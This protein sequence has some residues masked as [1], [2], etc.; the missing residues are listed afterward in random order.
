VIKLS[1]LVVRQ[2]YIIIV[3]IETYASLH[4][5]IF[6][7][8]CHEN[9]NFTFINCPVHIVSG[10]IQEISDWR[11]PDRNGIYPEKDL[12]RQWPE[13]GPETAWVFEGR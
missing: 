10:K 5:H 3:I 13:E 6:N 4:V 12:L 2:S 7:I 9:H 8:D 1:D 11:G